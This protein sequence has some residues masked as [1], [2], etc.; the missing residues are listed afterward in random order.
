[1]DIGPQNTPN[2]IIRGERCW[3]RGFEPADLEHYKRAVNDASTAHWAGFQQPQNDGFMASF[4][5]NRANGP[6]HFYVISPLGETA[7]VGTIWLWNLGGRLGGAELSMFLSDAG[8]RGAG[9]GRDAVNAMLD[10]G[11]GHTDTYRIWLTTKTENERA[12]RAFA[13]AG[14]QDDGVVRGH[15][16]DRGRP[17][18]SRLMSIL[19]PEWE[20]LDRPRSWDHWRL[21]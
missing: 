2:P 17:F 16:R 14:F 13:A 10:F 18:D 3:I 4:L 9:L 15:A 21:D 8:S 1:M 20:A 7:F 6:E 5:E 11:F 12:Q 19:R